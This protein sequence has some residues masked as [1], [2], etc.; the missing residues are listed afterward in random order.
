MA[1]RYNPDVVLATFERREYASVFTMA[2]PHAQAG[3][4]LAQDMIALLYQCGLG[5]V[6]NV[7]EAERWLLKAAE[8]NDPIAWNNLGTL[9]ISEPELQH[10]RSE[11]RRCYERASELGL[12]VAEPY[13]PR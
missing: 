7:F 8:Q 12:D 3:N 4:P 5:V 10:R 6:R 1:D 11:A 13:P 2:L 9:Y